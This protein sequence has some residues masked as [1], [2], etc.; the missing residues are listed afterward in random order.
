[1][2]TTRAGQDLDRLNQEYVSAFHNST[3]SFFFAASTAALGA[4]MGF[5]P[6]GEVTFFFWA[7]A[8]AGAL[9]LFGLGQRAKALRLENELDKAGYFRR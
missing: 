3:I 2:R 6:G 4:L 7:L 1:M 9:A 5:V 8:G